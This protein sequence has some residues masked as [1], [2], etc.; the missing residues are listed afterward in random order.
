MPDSDNQRCDE[1]FSE[2]E[3]FSEEARV[4]VNRPFLEELGLELKFAPEEFAPPIDEPR[5]IAFVRGKASRE[6]WHAVWG[7]IS[8]YRSWFDAWRKL[9]RLEVQ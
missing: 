2:D 1:L 9:M 3:P 6:E 8:A 7:L 5:L 4:D